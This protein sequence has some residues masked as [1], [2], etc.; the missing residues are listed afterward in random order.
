MY[1]DPS[2]TL[3]HL[4]QQGIIDITPITYEDFLP[5]S[6]AGI[7]R[8]NL[9]TQASSASV[10]ALSNEAGMEEALG[11]KLSSS[12]ELYKTMEDESIRKCEVELGIQIIV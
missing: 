11:A 6:A 12:D 10:D 2:F 9:G 5:L 4:I 8:S 1:D 3:E 7:F